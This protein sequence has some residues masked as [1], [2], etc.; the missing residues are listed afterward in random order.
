M[1][2]KSVAVSAESVKKVESYR[3]VV[4]GILALC[5]FFVFFHR[6]AAGVMRSDLQKAFDIGPAEFSVLAACYFYTYTLMQLPA[7][8]LADALGA[9]KTVAG[10]MLVAA[11][12]S[13]IF[14][15]APTITVAYIG[16]AVVG[17]GV[18]VVF[19]PILVIQTQWFYPRNFGMLTGLTGV[20]GNLGGIAAQTPLLFLLGAVGWRNSF[21]AVGIISVL[22]FLLVIAFVKSSPR[23][24]GLP[25]IAEIEGREVKAAAT[26]ISIGKSLKTIAS[27]PLTWL[28]T[29]II[30]GLMGAYITFSSA[31]GVSLLKAKFNVDA[32]TA[33]N[34]NLVPLL[35]VAVVGTFVGSISDK[36]RN[37]KGVMIALTSIYLLTWILFLYVDIPSSMYYPFM[38]LM[39]VGTCALILT[40]TLAKEYND[41]RV[42]GMSTAFVNTFA[43][44]AGAIFPVII[45]K[46]MAKV[47]ENP[48]FADYVSAFSWMP[49][50]LG[51]T[52]VASFLLK[53]TK[54][55]NIY[56]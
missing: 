55:E 46:A 24:M 27:N 5:Y 51:I 26:K 44:A 3:W 47:G 33:A 49:V 38:F 14:A 16:R 31:W 34:G 37:R 30:A 56:K 32:A 18:A 2:E 4:Y 19:I 17:A 7:G 35:A 11:L 9:K 21:I 22:L 43:F 29:V 13:L 8:I 15:F 39:G 42:A 12:G 28:T 50:V 20:F 48:T 52:V 40:W 25:T 36:L 54:A 6:M 1:S 23:D 41:P 45:G 10:G 53:E